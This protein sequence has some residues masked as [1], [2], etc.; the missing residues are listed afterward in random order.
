MHNSL[1][2]LA[3]LLTLS[4]NAQGRDRPADESAVIEAVNDRLSA[5]RI[6]LPLPLGHAL[7]T[8]RD[9]ITLRGSRQPDGSFSFNS[10]DRQRLDAFVA[11]GL[12]TVEERIVG[13][14]ER[15]QP[16]RLY[17]DTPRADYFRRDPRFL[18]AQPAFCYGE[19]RLVQILLIEEPRRAAC[20]TSRFVNLLYRF[21]L[22]P[23]WIDHPD[24]AEAYP[25]RLRPREADLVHFYRMPLMQSVE[26]WV[27]DDIDRGHVLCV[28]EP[29]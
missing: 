15:S 10:V 8:D 17:R 6:C 25:E 4:A 14:G 20:I 5:E 18:H 11:V 2:L 29:R 9:A 22:V 7:A 24:I 26:G 1:H 27:F 12:M 19:K 16:A 23:D 3:F 28:D 13:Q 21:D